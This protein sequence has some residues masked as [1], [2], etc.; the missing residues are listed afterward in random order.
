MGQTRRM[1]RRDGIDHLSKQLQQLRFLVRS[2]PRRLARTITDIIIQQPSAS[3]V[4]SQTGLQKGK[5]HI[6]NGNSRHIPAGIELETQKR[7]E[8][9]LVQAPV[10]P[11][12]LPAGLNELRIAA[13]DALEG[14]FARVGAARSGVGIVRLEDEGEAAL[15]HLAADPDLLAVVEG[16]GLA[17]EGVAG[18]GIA[19]TAKAEEADGSHAKDAEE[20][21]DQPQQEADDGKE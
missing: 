5:Q 8:V 9:A 15:G 17:G 7:H 13:V 21:I 16:Q 12:L 20:G 14:I 18:G 19:G 11:G 10:H 2:P 3:N 4:I 6:T 1:H